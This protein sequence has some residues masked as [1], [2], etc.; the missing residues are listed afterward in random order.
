[1]ETS[2]KVLADRLLGSW[3]ARATH[4]HL[5]GVVVH[6]TSSFE[7]LGDEGFL[8]HRT[9]YDHPALPDALSLLRDG[10]QHYFDTR[11]VMR[12]FALSH[13]SEGWSVVRP[14]LGADFGQRM[15]WQLEQGGTAVSGRSQLSHDGVRWEDD[16]A[17]VYRRR[18]LP[19][20][21]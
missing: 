10:Q 4:T 9:Q 12:L 15:T 19:G 14:Q 7:R 20:S 8:V 13:T 1:M 17:V 18:S 2:W 5:P 16:L 3:E 21:E 11:G 6:G